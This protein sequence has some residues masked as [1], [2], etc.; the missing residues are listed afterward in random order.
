[1]TDGGFLRQKRIRY[2]QREGDERRKGGRWEEEGDGWVR[3]RTAVLL[4]ENSSSRTSS[5][6][7]ICS[8]SHCRCQ[9]RPVT[10]EREGETE[11]WGGEEVKREREREV[12]Q[13]GCSNWSFWE[14]TCWHTGGGGGGVCVCVSRGGL[15]WV[16]GIVCVRVCS[17]TYFVNVCPSPN[18]YST[19][20]WFGH[21]TC[22]Q[23]F[24]WYCKSVCVH[25]CV[26]V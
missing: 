24:D 18:M 9:L 14:Q 8:P 13:H 26:C 3:E 12:M 17:C 2:E 1:M 21:T 5:P 6:S 16:W 15:L 10:W 20:Q 25:V 4:Q 22:V 11:K 23:T 19:S 7:G